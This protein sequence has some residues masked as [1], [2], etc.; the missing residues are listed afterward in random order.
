MKNYKVDE[1]EVRIILL[2]RILEET[3]KG[4]TKD[5]SDDHL[6]HI[7]QK[8]VFDSVLLKRNDKDEIKGIVK[9]LKYIQK[10]RKPMTKTYLNNL[11]KTLDKELVNADF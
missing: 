11:L 5:I 9:E 3:S 6:F 1:D 4:I 8:N 2:R 7:A 10:N